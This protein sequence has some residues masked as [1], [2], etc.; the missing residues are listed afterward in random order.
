M[1]QFLPFSLEPSWQNFL[2][3]ELT[4]PYLIELAAFVE[5]EY[6]QFPDAIYPPRSL[7]FNAFAQTPVD[8]VKVILVGQDPYHGPNQAHGLSFSVPA[9][10][11]VPPSL[12]NVYKELYQDLQIPPS[13]NGCLLP[14]ASQGVLLLNATLT[15]KRSTPMSHHGR[16]WEKFTDAVLKK[17]ANQ[18]APLVF[19]LWGKSAQEKCRFLYAV[20]IFNHGS[21][22]PN[23]IF[24]LILVYQFHH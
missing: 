5:K 22:S 10:K 11:K 1:T 15:V 3:E 13:S 20:Y 2:K 21:V 4:Q 24:K 9:G 23:K 16:G 7:I 14:W 8:K 18:Q 17:L 6:A 19:V 12:Q